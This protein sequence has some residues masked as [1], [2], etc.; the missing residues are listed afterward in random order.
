MICYFSELRAQ[1]VAMKDTHTQHDKQISIHFNM[2]LTLTTETN[3]QTKRAKL[4]NQMNMLHTFSKLW[5][6]NIYTDRYFALW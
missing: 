6:Y 4:D 1:F 3:T 5:A 2:I